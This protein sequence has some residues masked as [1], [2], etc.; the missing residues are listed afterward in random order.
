VNANLTVEGVATIVLAGEADATTV[1]ALADLLAEAAR[2]APDRLVLDVAGLVHLP[3]AVL[4][5]L[6]WA[7][8]RLGRDVRIAVVGASAEVADAL[9][10]ASLAHTVSLTG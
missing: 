10:L 7:H 1:P 6:V 2:A 9:R 8:Q 3:A 5:C 4:R